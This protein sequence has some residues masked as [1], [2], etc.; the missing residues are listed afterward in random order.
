MPIH[1]FWHPDE[2]EALKKLWSSPKISRENLCDLFDRSYGSIRHKAA[3][4]GLPKRA[5]IEKRLDEILYR[6]LL[7]VVEG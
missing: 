2:E 1:R 3:S 4:M 6:K 7:E 5:E